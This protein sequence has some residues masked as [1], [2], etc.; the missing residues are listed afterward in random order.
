MAAAAAAQRPL[1]DAAAAQRPLR[2]AAAALEIPAAR[3]VL[4]GLGC[5]VA[6]IVSGVVIVASI[7]SASFNYKR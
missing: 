1:R 4:P 6:L 2:D 3:H 5:V 7:V